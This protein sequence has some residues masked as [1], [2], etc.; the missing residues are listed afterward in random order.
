MPTSPKT[1][2]VWRSIP[3]AAQQIINYILSAVNRIF[4]PRDDNYPDIGVQPFS[5]DIANRKDS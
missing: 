3:Q 1:L 4:A 2:P 5:G